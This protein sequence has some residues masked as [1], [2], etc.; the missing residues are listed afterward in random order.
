MLVSHVIDVVA[1]RAAALLRLRWFVRAPIWFYRARLGLLFGSR[2]LMLEHVGRSSGR[3]RHM[4]LEIVARPSD[5]RYIVVSGFGARAQW[6]RNVCA[7]PEVR[8]QLG[9]HRP[10]P[11]RAT[12]LTAAQSTGL[13]AEYAAAHPRSWRT[14]KPVFER[15]LGAEITDRTAGL[16]LVALDRVPL[17]H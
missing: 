13:L 4:V 11:A 7:D 17:S 12:A 2:L 9:G 10:V 3:R 14:L 1:D 5:G 16:P 8:I 6:Y 15:T